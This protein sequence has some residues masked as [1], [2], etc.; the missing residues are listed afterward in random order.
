MTLE[1]KVCG[2]TRSNDIEKIQKLDVDHI[3]F[4]NI[5]RSKRNVT[6]DEIC[7]LKYDLIDK[8]M[9]VLVVEPENP[10]EAI[11]KTSFT[12]I[13]NI[14]LHSLN[15]SDLKFISWFNQYY[16]PNGL[17]ITK[18]VPITGKLTD[19]KI[20]EIVNTS[21]CAN[22]ILFDYEKDGLSGGTNTQ[23]P[24]DTAVKASKLVKQN[25]PTTK[26][27]LAGGINLEY[28]EEIYDKLHYFDRI[29][30]NSGVEDAPGCKNIGEI[31][32]ILKLTNEFN[33]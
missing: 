33:N 1:V 26:T 29:D 8:T 31:K 14:Q 20:H 17:N 16:S 32:K 11:M 19:A 5:E 22:N 4:I 9:A 3:G 6:L 23:I 10:Y 28:L 27:T 21:L 12:K 30:I 25:Y 24:I 15:C 7:S 13:G 2:I 18:V